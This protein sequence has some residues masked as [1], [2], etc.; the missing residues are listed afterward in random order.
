[1]LLNN[2]YMCILSLD[3]PVSVFLR[4]MRS[5]PRGIRISGCVSIGL[6]VILYMSR[7]ALVAFE[8]GDFVS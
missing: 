3:I 8:H 6:R 5:A 7:I 2:K 4:N 1:M